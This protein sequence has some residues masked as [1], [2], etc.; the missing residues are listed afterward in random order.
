MADR[1]ILMDNARGADCAALRT[2]LVRALGP[3]ATGYADLA[4]GDDFS[5]AV[6]GALARWQAEAGLVADGICGPCCQHELGLRALPDLEQPLEARAVSRLFPATRP[7]GIVRHLPYLAAALAAFN[8]VDRPL[9]LLALAVIRAEC[10]GFVPI[11]EAPSHGNTLPGLAPFSA[12]E[13]RFGNRDT[14]DGARYRGRGFVRLTGRGRYHRAG[15][16]LGIDLEAA[17]D[18]A[19]APEVAA[20]LLAARISERADDL[21]AALARGDLRRARR[22]INGATHGFD[23]FRDVFHRAETFGP[24]PAVPQA[25]ASAHRSADSGFAA[26]RA[27]LDAI[28]DAVDLRDRPYQPP[29]ASLPPQFPADP[30][31]HRLFA[32]YAR[33]GLILD[34]G[35]EGA[36]TGFGL[37]CV[38]NYLR[39]RMLGMPAQL[40]PVSARM[41]YDLA[42]R[43]DEYEGEDYE[44]SS[45]RG[46]LK[47]WS[48][49]GVCLEED[50]PYRPGG[51]VRPRPGWVER[52]IEQTLGVYYR[53]DTTALC[54][55]QAAILQ[56]GAVYASAWTHAGWDLAGAAGTPLTGH[57]SLPVIPYHGQ[58]SRSG[59]HAFALVGFNRDGFVVQNSWGRSWGADG[60]AVLTYA[61]WLAHAM[62][63]WTTALGVAGVV[64]GRMTARGTPAALAVARDQAHWW[65][66]EQAYTH[67][68]VL[69]NNGRVSRYLHQDAVS[70]TLR[71]QTG[72][73]PDSWFRATATERKRL[74]LYA[75]GGL[76]SE[77]D[78]IARAR[79]M[80]RYCTGNGC[81]PLFVAWKTG[82]LETIA[83]I[84]A[85]RIGLA[86][87][88]AATRTPGELITAAT[89]RM[90]ET[91]IGR[92]F[93]RPLWSEMKENAALAV[94]PG[95]GGDLLTDGLRHLA[96]LW[97]DQFEL[98]LIGHSA[99]AILLGHLVQ[100]L[101]RR[102]LTRRVA[103]VHLYAP[104]C[105]V[106]FANR[107]WAPHT[108]LMRHLHLDLLTDEIEQQDHV[109]GLYRK[110]LLY[111]IA[112]ALEADPATPILGLARVF[113]A[114][115]Q[116]WDGSPDTAET[117][118]NWRQAAA[119][120]GLGRRLALHGNRTITTRLTPEKSAPA[121][122]GGFDN[123]LRVIGATLER[124]TGKSTLSL[125][126]DDLVGF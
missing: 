64:D 47:G 53:I 94:Q 99:G 114:D 41:L 78:A 121:S 92:P 17:P 107:Y 55:L 102:D 45:C 4:T 61:D 21:R 100:L 60:F 68:I 103:S 7:S 35:L 29:V 81:Y 62:D 5:A 18:L 85:E 108:E 50:W 6:K 66:E 82:P 113:D 110:S 11:G 84:I 42:R 43:Y 74:I 77:A 88:G 31:I 3:A 120:A 70:R 117:L 9:I 32:A 112:N 97:G 26:V 106:A 80:G 79:V 44:G 46:A 8:L 71:H 39:W 27:E 83:N 63:A 98:H 115:S 25:V 116:G 73:L 75:H 95:R 90:I 86:S 105:T 67:S 51:A 122:H 69:G 33:A 16:L 34:Q 72:V 14:G 91:A 123:D 126:V 124:I 59:G 119:R 54:D 57:A 87:R 20:C 40:P 96:D 12:Y 38:I 13:G 58:R 104:A 52:A 28:G 23:R 24:L 49:H 36:C 89:D 56:I 19:N 2:A 65:S 30:D 109:L 93:A 48:R 15:A 10:E 22:M 101:A 118:A 37:A 76:N 111:L 125:P 1:F